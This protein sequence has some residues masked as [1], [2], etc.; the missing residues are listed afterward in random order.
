MLNLRTILGILLLL[1]APAMA[2]GAE[3][4][5]QVDPATQDLVQQGI[6]LRRSGKDEAALR[7]FLDA[8]ARS[9]SSVR[10]LLHVTA[11]AQ[12]TGRWLLAHQYLQKAAQHRSDPYYQRHRVSVQAVE[13]AVAQRVGQ[14]RVVGAPSGAE[15]L[16][17]GEVVGTLPMDVPRPL[18]VG[19]YQLEVRKSGYFSVRRPF[20]I[21]GGAHLSQEA[22][23]LKPA[24]PAR[25]AAGEARAS[26]SAKPSSEAPA[27]RGASPLRARWITFALAGTG[28]ALMATSGVAFAIRER[29]AS[30]WND[31][32]RCLDGA[33]PSLTRQQ[34]CG[35]TRSDA[36]TAERV[37]IVTGVLGLGLG[38][39]AL[40]H[41]LATSERGQERT[42][43]LPACDIGLGS[44]ACRGT[45]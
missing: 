36:K 26:G 28:V 24:A 9:P 38:G 42:G 35:D 4:D 2:Q 41:W 21:V 27:G 43:R 7:A 25:D 29:E 15:V 20:E 1:G 22:V 12:A 34:L 45:F 44:V 40:A 19:S 11:A 3:E 23:E 16:V 5:G 33:N 13:D 30:R 14:L 18:E 32:E 6:Q 10:V 39:A 37:G 17:N 31:N 8:E